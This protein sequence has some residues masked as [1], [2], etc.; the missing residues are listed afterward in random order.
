MSKLIGPDFIALQVCDLEVS[1]RFYVEQLKLTPAEK[2]PPGAVLSTTT[3]LPC[4]IRNPL[5]D[6]AASEHL[7]WGISLWLACDDAEIFHDR[8]KAA[9]I[10]I[11]SPLQDGPFGRFFSFKDP[12]GY[13]IT[14]HTKTAHIE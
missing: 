2:S 9:G 5:I 8:L 13:G 10:A 12:D 3:P 4:A 6:L 7:G 14:L 11:L 1:K